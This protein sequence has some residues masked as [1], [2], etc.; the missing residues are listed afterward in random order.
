MEMI[1][2]RIA[3]A[4]SQGNRGGNPAGVVLLSSEQT[5]RL[6]DSQKA[7]IATEV[8][9]SE[10]A[11]VTLRGPREFG[12]EFW[13][14][15]KRILDCGH[16]TIASLGVWS[17]TRGLEEGAWKKVLVD[18]SSRDLLVTDKTFWSSQPRSRFSNQDGV[19][20]GDQGVRFALFELP[21]TDSLKDLAV[22]QA[23]ILALSEKL[24]LVGVYYF[25]R[26]QEGPAAA[27]TRMFA[28][29]YGI[30]EESATGMAAGILASYLVENGMRDKLFAIE[31]GVFMPNPSPSTLHIRSEGDLVWVGGECITGERRI[32]FPL[33]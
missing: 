7:M 2:A 17:N 8:G 14:P 21:S 29:R 33:T 27:T 22:D 5:A 4:F 18:G 32:P 12:F 13:T 9:A 24:D 20:V 30:P 31:Q 11:F 25:V 19:I 16:A 6:T 28:P 15:N 3:H 26:L 1:E 23:Q 10:T